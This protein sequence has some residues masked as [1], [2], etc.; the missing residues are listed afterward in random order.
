M[1]E[2]LGPMGSWALREDP[3]FP[4]HLPELGLSGA[5]AGGRV[6]VV[7]RA[8]HAAVFRGSRWPTL[9]ADAVVRLPQTGCWA[10]SPEC[11]RA[12]VSAW[13]RRLAQRAQSSPQYLFLNVLSHTLPCDGLTRVL[14]RK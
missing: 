12:A 2:V 1:P 11:M 9:G 13:P 10:E 3:T 7:S 4:V 6:E 8:A 5:E 14:G